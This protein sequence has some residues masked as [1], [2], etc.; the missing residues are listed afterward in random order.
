M[1][2][3]TAWGMHRDHRGHGGMIRSDAPYGP[4]AIGCPLAWLSPVILEMLLIG[5]PLQRSR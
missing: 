3:G 1:I 5:G 4:Y 2:A